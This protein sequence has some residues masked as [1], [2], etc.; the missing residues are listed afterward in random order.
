MKTLRGLMNSK[1]ERVKLAA[2]LRAADILLAHQEGEER[3][4][5]AIERAAAR[6]AEA[7]AAERPDAVPAPLSAE[8]A[9]RAFLAQIRERETATNATAD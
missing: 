3:A 7:E 6:K 5:I 9:A 1:S 4:A 8:E 2:A